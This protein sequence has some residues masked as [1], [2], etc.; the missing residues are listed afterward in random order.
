MR[1]ISL[2]LPLAIAAIVG[3]KSSGTPSVSDGS[4]SIQSTRIVGV[5][6]DL[7]VR[8]NPTLSQGVVIV[9][10]S[11]A[12]VWRELSAAYDSVGIPVT[13]SNPGQ[14][15]LGNEAFR[16]RRRLKDV[17]LTRYIDC[18]STQGAPSAESYEIVLVINTQLQPTP[19]GIRATT[20]LRPSGRPVA[21][22]GGFINC[23]S[24]GRLEERI[25]QLIGGRPPK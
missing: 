14:G 24:T 25:G 17:P 11:L 8:T 2:F 12:N 21:L 3:C 23:T 5:N 16:V 7:E 22:S 1:H 6:S 18:G 20:S 13:S 19:E 15:V 9:D 10:G 4:G